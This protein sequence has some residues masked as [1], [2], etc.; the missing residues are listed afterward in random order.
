MQEVLED[1]LRI[2]FDKNHDNPNQFMC[3][4][5]DAVLRLKD[6]AE[7]WWRSERTIAETYPD[8]Y[9]HKWLDC[10]LDV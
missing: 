1:A 10:V 2:L 9:Q 4:V 7:I 8:I 3:K 5:V 6:L